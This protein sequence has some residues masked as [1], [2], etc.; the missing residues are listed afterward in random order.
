MVKVNCAKVSIC[1]RHRNV[2]IQCSSLRGRPTRNDVG[3][4]RLDLGTSCRRDVSVSNSIVLSSIVSGLASNN[5]GTIV[6]SVGH[7]SNSINFGGT[8]TAISACNSIT[9]PTASLGNSISGLG[10]RSLLTINEI[11]YCVSGLIPRGSESTTVLSSGK[12]PCASDGKGACLGPSSRAT[13][14]CVGSVVTRTTSTKVAIFILSN[15]SL[16]RTVTSRCSNNF[17][18]LTTGLCGSLN[19]SVG[20]IGKVSISLS[21][22]SVNGD[23]GRRDGR[24]RHTDHGTRRNGSRRDTSR[25]AA[26]SAARGGVGR[27]LP[28]VSADERI[29]FVATTTSG[30]RAGSILRSYKVSSCVLTS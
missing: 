9:F 29:C 25:R 8:L 18:G 20:F 22:D 15:A 17:S 2:P 3:R 12:V 28:R 30:T 6:V 21:T 13:C 24:R 4:V 19:A 16:P 5:C 27:L 23:R 11:C 7:S 1:V 26:R 10:R 14:G